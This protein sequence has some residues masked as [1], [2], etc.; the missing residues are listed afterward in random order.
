MGGMEVEDPEL[1]EAIRM[2]LQESMPQPAQN[3][4]PANQGGQAPQAE[5]QGQ[6]RQQTEEELEQLAIRLSLQEAQNQ[7]GQKK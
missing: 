1:A 7:Q 4:P 5:G 2:S 3:N 6:Q